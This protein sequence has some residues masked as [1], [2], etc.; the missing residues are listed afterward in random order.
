MTFKPHRLAPLHVQDDAVAIIDGRIDGFLA[1]LAGQLKEFTSVKLVKPGQSL[2]HLVGANPAPVDMSNI[3]R[4]TRQD[5]RS[6]EGMKISF[7]GDSDD[8]CAPIFGK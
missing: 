1:G 7:G 4:F 2:L 3:C 5:G 6:R 8:I